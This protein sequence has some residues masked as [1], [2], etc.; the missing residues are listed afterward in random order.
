MYQPKTTIP[1]KDYTDLLAAF[2]PPTTFEP[3]K[4]KYGT[5]KNSQNIFNE[6]CVKGVEK[7]ARKIEILQSTQAD[8]SMVRKELECILQELGNIRREIAETTKSIPQDIEKFGR[9]RRNNPIELKDGQKLIDCTKICNKQH[10][11]AHENIKKLLARYLEKMLAKKELEGKAYDDNGNPKSRYLIKLYPVIF[12]FKHKKT[13]KIIKLEHSEN[14]AKEINTLQNDPSYQVGLTFDCPD[15]SLTATLDY[16]FGGKTPDFKYLVVGEVQLK[17]DDDQY[18]R[19]TRHITYYN[20]SLNE[21]SRESTVILQHTPSENHDLIL[22]K[23]AALW[24]QA[25]FWKPESGTQ[26]FNEIMADIQFYLGQAMFFYRGSPA[27]SKM[28]SKGTYYAYG[29]LQPASQS[30]TDEHCLGEWYPF[31]KLFRKKYLECFSN[32]PTSLISQAR[33]LA[34]NENKQSDVNNNQDNTEENNQIA[35]KQFGY[36]K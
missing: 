28:F 21:F 27:I 17:V 5:E 4:N 2:N 23:I 13:H 32:D 11:E 36:F 1:L 30:A 9:S 3:T 8:V 16:L 33:Q 10:M 29:F 6:Q 25:I 7:V 24:H 22:D 18:I 35:N 19:G 31:M 14:N 20:D 34:S 15:E 26:K 12:Q